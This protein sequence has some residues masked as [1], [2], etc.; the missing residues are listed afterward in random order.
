MPTAHDRDPVGV[1]DII[2]NSSTSTHDDQASII[3]PFDLLLDEDEY[4]IHATIDLER[5]NK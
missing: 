4:Q 3:A 2:Q 5:I 1:Q